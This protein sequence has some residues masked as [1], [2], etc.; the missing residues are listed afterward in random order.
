MKLVRWVLPVALSSLAACAWWMAGRPGAEILDQLTF[1]HSAHIENDVECLT[2]HQGVDKAGVNAAS[3]LPA[4]EACLECHDKEDN[5]DMCH[6]DP[7]KREPRAAFSSGLQFSHAFHVPKFAEEGCLRCHG[8]V[9]ESTELPVATP[10]RE[11][12]ADCHNPALDHAGNWIARH[13]PLARGSANSCTQCHSQAM[14]ADC[15]SRVAPEAKARIYPEAV[16]QEHIHRGDWLTSHPLEARADG[17]T[18]LRCHGGSFCQECHTASGVTAHADTVRP[19]HPAGYAMRGGDAFH[20]DDARMHIET[21]AACHDQGPASVCV[22]CHK[23]GGG[24]GSPHPSGWK[25]RY[26]EVE[27]DNPMC[28][29][30]HIGP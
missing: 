26:G 11:L 21:C 6:S 27:N 8:N 25:D 15:H 13:G 30:C 1:D 2:C 29:Y 19:P 20:G 3:L 9:A 16:G 4:E 14:C 18:C 10:T 22:D 17:D 28:L 23:V 24:G 12:C 5:C 7:E